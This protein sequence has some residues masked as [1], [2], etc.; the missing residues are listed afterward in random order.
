[1]HLNFLFLQTVFHPMPRILNLLALS[2]LCMLSHAA[3]R[4]NIIV[5]LADDIGYTD[6][7][8]YGGEIETPHLDRLAADGLRFT[9]FYNAGRCCPTR[10]SLLTGL[11]PHQA[12]VGFMMA[13]WGG[14]Y[15]GNLSK[16]SVT[17]AEVLKGAGYR[18]Y[19]SGKWHVTRHV[20]PKSASEQYNWPLQRGFDRFYGSIFGGGS[21]YDP[22]SLAR[23]NT[24]ISPAADPEY[25]PEQYYY[26]DAI[27]DNAIR[28]IDEH[29]PSAPFCLYVAY[30]AAH[31]PLQA[32]PEDIA[33][34][35][36][37]YDA[38]YA[39]IREAR[40]NR[41]LELG[42]IG[43]NSKLSPQVGDWEAQPDQEW[44]SACM[45]VYAAMV[46][47]MDR[48]IGRIM[49]KLEAEG[50][51]DNTLVLYLQDNGGC[52]ENYGRK[53]EGPRVERA[54]RGEPMAADELQNKVT[55]EKSREGYA[56][57][58][59]HVMPGPPDTAIGYGLNWANV[60][61]SPFRMY[62]QYVHEGGISTPLIVHWP[63]GIKARNELRHTP[64]HVIDI[65]ATCVDVARAEYPVRYDGNAILP[66]EGKSLVPA[67]AG[68]EIPREFL[69]W[70]HQ[71]NRAIRIGDWKL[72][73]VGK[74]GQDD[75]AWELY[76]LSVDRSELNDLSATRPEKLAQII[77]AWSEQAK[78]TQVLP[79]PTIPKRD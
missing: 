46:D 10:A 34:Y 11:Y 26:T 8:C 77:A 29:D 17:I 59:G 13:D 4:P 31:W 61:N 30:T 74:H 14:A 35:E 49:A 2:T 24:L 42:V 52:A 50:L 67:F 58:R 18:C 66:M 39:P 21:Y 1:M 19:M 3:E 78:R 72:V 60:S 55:P 54:E 47:R 70:E 16:D 25:K 33:K 68:K 7:G 71:G 9:Q 53:M 51:F 76:D 5:I 56:T 40:Y 43:A 12:D 69:F 27:T 62:K 20:N 22:R 64:G 28:Y 23:D 79:W 38:G 45:E 65:M 57:R 41:A 75:V 63:D 36:S 73:A 48:G 44:E 15:S 32:F 6:I 37:K